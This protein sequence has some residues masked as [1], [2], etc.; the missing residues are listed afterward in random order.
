MGGEITYYNPD[1]DYDSFCKNNKD[2]LKRK[3]VGVFLVNLAK[4]KVVNIETVWDIITHLQEIIITNLDEENKSE[5]N[6]ELS[7]IAGDMI[8]AGKESLHESILW[9]TIIGNIN[10]LSSKRP[11]QHKSLSTKAI[12]KNM[13]LI[14]FIDNAL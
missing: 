6:V 13:D 11:K 2:N 7:E 14:D 9:N 8:I 1:T 12:F 5:I 10:I 3:S 4:L